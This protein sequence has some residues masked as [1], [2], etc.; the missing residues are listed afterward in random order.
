MR[1]IDG[2][3]VGC[4]VG[5]GFD[6]ILAYGLHRLYKRALRSAINIE[7][8]LKVKV[9]MAEFYKWNCYSVNDA[10]NN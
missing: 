6:F 8:S 3:D 1:F 2:V 5:I 7:V 10:I 4:L 9:Q